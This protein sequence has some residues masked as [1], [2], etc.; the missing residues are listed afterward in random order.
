MINEVMALTASSKRNKPP[1]Y[2]SVHNVVNLENLAAMPGTALH[3][4][5]YAVKGILHTVKPNVLPSAD[6]AAIME[7]QTP[8]ENIQVKAFL[9]PQT[10]AQMS[11]SRHDD[12]RCAHVMALTVVKMDKPLYNNVHSCS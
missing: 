4:N 3:G 2:T 8:S 1:H 10:K 5:K 6:T 11:G 12:Y 9:D 7:F